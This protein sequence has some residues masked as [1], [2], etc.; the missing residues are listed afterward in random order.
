MNKYICVVKGDILQAVDAANAKGLVPEVLRES[1]GDVT[2]LV[3]TTLETL[4]TWF[5]DDVGIPRQPGALL[6]YNPS[7]P[8]VKPEPRFPPICINCGGPLGCV[9]HCE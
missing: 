4:A 3:E 8:P 1:A 6:F 7:S 5:G 2:L 9:A